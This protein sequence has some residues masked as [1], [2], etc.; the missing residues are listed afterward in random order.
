MPGTTFAPFGLRP[1][2]KEGGT[3]A[4]LVVELTILST[5]ATNILMY[6]PVKIG[7]DGTLQAAAPG[8]AFV[9]AFMGV[10]Y[11]DPTQQRR[12]VSN[13]W[14]AGTVATEIVAWYTRDPYITYEIQADDVV[15]QAQIGGQ[16][17]LT[18]E[19]GST[20][21]GLSNVALDASTIV[22]TGEFKQVRLIGFAH[23][24]D[25]VVEAA[26]NLFPTIQVQ[27][28]DHQYVAGRNAF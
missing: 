3:P 24:I 23:E 14:I 1:A 18:A 20:T 11:T 15:T 7:T 27:I 6:G 2:Y 21:T 13:K 12:I 16:A 8:D 10:Q 9:G 19:S 28:S 5:Y 22:Q 17:D 25:D 26:D 4:S